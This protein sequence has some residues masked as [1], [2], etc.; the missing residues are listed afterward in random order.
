MGER[1]AMYPE[2]YP[3]LEGRSK[4]VRGFALS[5]AGTFIFMV[6]SVASVVFSSQWSF[7]FLSG[8]SLGS[9]I[10]IYAAHRSRSFFGQVALLI[11]ASGTLS[12]ET[13][14]VALVFPVP[15]AAACAVLTL[16]GCLVAARGMHDVESAVALEPLP[17]KRR[18]EMTVEQHASGGE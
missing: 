18:R 2:L 17:V 8:F 7:A 15:L 11:M 6:T 10:L 4:K 5:V 12:A 13:A 9:I 16:G 14:I 1:E 3:E